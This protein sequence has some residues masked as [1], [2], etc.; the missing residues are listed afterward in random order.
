MTEYALSS[1][2]RDDIGHIFDF[3]ARQ[4]GHDQAAGT[5]RPR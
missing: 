4:W 3:T 5:A 1:A 2:A